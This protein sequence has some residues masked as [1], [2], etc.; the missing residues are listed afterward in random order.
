M[1][2]FKWLFGGLI[3]GAVGAA[4]WIAIG[5]F[6]HAEVGYIAWGIGFLAGVG[7]R[8]AAGDDD[9]FG[10]GFTAVIAAIGMILLS[11]YVV[12]A[13][14]LSAQNAKTGELSKMMYE[15]LQKQSS[16]PEVRAICTR[17][18]EVADEWE[19]RGRKLTWPEGMNK[20]EAVK[21]ADFPKGVWAEATKRWKNLPDMERRQAVMKEEIFMD[22]TKDAVRPRSTSEV[23][24]ESFSPFDILWFILASVT[25]FSGGAALVS[26]SDD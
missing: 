15:A 23:F 4:I 20:M 24:Q 17:A 16:D 1:S 9:G 26:N 18:G 8:V 2:F 11:K 13:L 21:E 22:M 14:L 25:A 7:V 19:K 5:Y 6:A 3:G 10:P 12:V